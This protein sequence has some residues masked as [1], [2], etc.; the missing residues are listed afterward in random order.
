PGKG[1][2]PWAEIGQALRRI[3]YDKNVVMEPFVLMGGEVGSDIK[4]W[5]SLCHDESKLDLD[6]RNS[7]AY[8]RHVFS[9]PYS[10]YTNA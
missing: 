7:V 2:L 4:I 3:G 1:Y 5:R 8:L 10:D 6:A 9:G